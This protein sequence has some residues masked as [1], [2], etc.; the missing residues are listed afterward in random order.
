MLPEEISKHWD[1]IRYGILSTS[2]PIMATTPEGIRNILKNLL[3]GSVQ[4]WGVISQSELGGEQMAGFALT[5]ITLDYISENRFL[6]IYDLFFINAPKEEIIQEGFN[7]IEE[8]AKANKCNKITAYTTVPA[9][10]SIAKRYGF[11]SDCRFIVK[12]V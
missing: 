11:N 7:A 9:I 6:N 10:L 1:M 12:E 4:C 3:N 2:T 5:T 8:F